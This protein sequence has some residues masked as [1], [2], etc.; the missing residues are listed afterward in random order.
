[1]SSAIAAI[2]AR[3]DSS[4]R[5]GLLGFS[6]G[7]YVAATTA[8]RDERVTALAVLYGGMPDRIAPS[9][10]HLPPLLELHGEADSNVPIV[11]GEELVK[12]AKAVGAPAE[13][14][15]YPGKEHG[16]D[17][18]DNDP[19]TANTISRVMKFFQSRLSTIG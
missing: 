15:R 12:L 8:A 19:A 2:L 13:M 7:G 18:A 5:L 17:F 14:V 6:R 9:V 11:R 16:F 4:G 3:P 1:V 10:K